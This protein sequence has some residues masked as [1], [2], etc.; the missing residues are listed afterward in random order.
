MRNSKDDQEEQTDMG[1]MARVAI[2][3]DLFGAVA[4]ATPVMALEPICSSPAVIFCEDFEATTLP[5][6][7]ADGYNPALHQIVTTQAHSGTKALQVTWP[8]GQDGGWLT[9]WL[10]TQNGQTPSVPWQAYDHVFV[11]AFWRREATWQCWPASL[12]CGKM[13]AQ[14]G[15]QTGM[16]GP[17]NPWSGFGQAGVTPKGTDWYYSALITT[18][19]PVSETFTIYTY[20]P[21][22][23][24]HFG[25]FNSSS[26]QMPLD[27]WACVEHELQVNTPGQHDGV[28]RIYING[29]L[30]KEVTGRRFRDTSNLQTGAVQ[31]TFSGS[32]INVPTQHEYV[33]DIVVSKQRIGCGIGVGTVPSDPTNVQVN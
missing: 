23:T 3:I 24:S 6:R 8:Q 15:L 31:L 33:D 19:T 12:A 13:I 1:V 28:E 14:Y 18:T 5:G 10:G 2:V 9:T 22:M 20:Y 30:A 29:V 27:Q 25:E 17:F 26:V 21:E 16:S 11:R 4:I 32:G 7:W